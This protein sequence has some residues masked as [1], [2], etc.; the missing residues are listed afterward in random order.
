MATIYTDKN[1]FEDILALLNEE[2]EKDD[3][4]VSDMIA[5]AENKIAQMERR[6]EYNKEHP[7]KSTAKGPSEETKKRANQIASV[8]TTEPM[9]AFEINAKL[10]TDFST[11]QIVNAV[12][13]IDSVNVQN[14]KV[15][16]MTANK[17]GL[18]SEK[19]YTAYF[20]G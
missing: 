17:Q 13:F 11:L 12:K 20:I 4:P 8:L 6:A 9:T 7:K 15:V 14:C 10:G 3:L 2:V 16:R 1:F 18:K 5:K 19:E